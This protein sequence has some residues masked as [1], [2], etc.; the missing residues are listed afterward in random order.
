M[1]FF[2]SCFILSVTSLWSALNDNMRQL[3]SC[4]GSY[5]L[6]LL[7]FNTIACSAYN[8]YYIGSPALNMH[9]IDECTGLWSILIVTSFILIIPIPIR[10][11]IYGIMIMTPFIILINLIR[12]VSV[13]I[14]S[15]YSLS[16]GD[17]VHAYIWRALYIILIGIVYFVYISWCSRTK[18]LRENDAYQSP[19]ATEVN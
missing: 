2:G 16:A 12:I 8:D 17:F 14:V 13:L 5:V 19:L 4:M 3:F 9:I 6:N 18:N 1:I 11:K 10:H 7:G 15:T